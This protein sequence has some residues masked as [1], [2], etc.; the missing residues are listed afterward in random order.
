MNQIIGDMQLHYVKCGKGRPMLLLHGNGEDHTIFTEA[1]AKLKKRFTLY[2]IDTRGH[3]RSTGGDNLHYTVF[4]DDMKAFI[5]SLSIK[6]PVVLGF[7]DGAITA[8]LLSSRYPDSVSAVIAAGANTSPGALVEEAVREMEEEYRKTHSPLLSLML[9]EPDITAEELQRI[10]VPVLVIAGENDLVRRSDT[11]YI[12]RSIRTSKLMI[13][14][15]EDHSSY[16]WHSAEIADIAISE[17]G[18]LC[19]EA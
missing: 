11:E 2:A 18:F 6:K 15:G 7:S 12:A 17:I 14:K 4:A 13:L 19:N 3:G 9:S 1:A 10:K 16:I 8:L 5:D